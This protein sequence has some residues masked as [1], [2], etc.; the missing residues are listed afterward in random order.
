[1]NVA[2]EQIESLKTLG[3][4]WKT[5]DGS[6]HR[7]P[8]RDGLP[9]GRGQIPTPQGGGRGRRVSAGGMKSTTLPADR[10]NYKQ[11]YAATCAAI[12]DTFRAN[13]ALIVLEDS[14]A[15]PSASIDADPSKPAQVKIKVSKSFKVKD[16]LKSDGYRYG[17]LS[18][19]WVK[20]IALD[21]LPAELLSLKMS[22]I[23]TIPGCMSYRDLHGISKT[24]T[25]ADLDAVA[26]QMHTAR[27]Q[28]AA[29]FNAANPHLIMKVV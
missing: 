16:S 26:E 22:G 19:E 12:C 6:K 28:I 7:K 23:A 2:P 27:V 11:Q 3:K 17:S 1:M 18:R 4:E 9:E 25:Q 10:E 13:P 5:P 8:D 24:A 21:A 15:M 14:S 29:A 20:S